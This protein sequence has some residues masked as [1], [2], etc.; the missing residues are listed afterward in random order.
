MPQVNLNTD[1]NFTSY[2]IHTL[3]TA[4]VLQW[5]ISYVVYSN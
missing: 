5:P 2:H 1:R 3:Y 4:L